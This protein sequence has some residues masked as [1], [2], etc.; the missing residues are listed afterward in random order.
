MAV[1]F[2][3]NSLEHLLAELERLDLFIRIQVWRVRQVVAVGGELQPYYVPEQEVDQLLDNMI[4]RPLW[5]AAP[6]PAELANDLQT[7]LDEMATI[8]QQRQIVARQQ[9]IRLRLNELV[10]LFDL[11]S[12][13]VDTLLL[14]LAPELD[15]GYNRLYAYLQDN[16]SRQRPTLDLLFNLFCRRIEEKVAAR[17]RFAAHAPLRHY[18]LIHLLPNTQESHAPWLAQSLKMDER[19]LNYLLDNDAVDA[20]LQPYVQL[21]QPAAVLDDLF[22]PP[23]FKE[24][25][26]GLA[27]QENTVLFYLQGPEGVGKQTTADA[28]CHFRQLRLL[29]VRGEHLATLKG[30]E[31][32][33]LAQ[34]AGREARLQGAAL[35][36]QG[37]DAL[38]TDEKKFQREQLLL[39]LATRPG[40]I[41]LAGNVPW[42]PTGGLTAVPFIHLNFPYPDSDQ[43]QQLWAGMLNG[44]AAELDL[45]DITN[46][47]RFTPGQIRDAAATAYNL[48]RRRDPERAV[49]KTEDIYTASRLHSNQKLAALAQKITPHYTWQDI[50][51]PRNCLNQLRELCQRLQYRSQVHQTWGFGAKIALGKGITALF[52][53]Q[54][55]TGK[56]MAADIIATEL[57]LDLYKIDLSTVVSKYIG[58]TEK[59][60]SRIFAEAET[61]H[62]ILFFDEADALFGKRTEVK[63]AHDRYANLEISYLL[64]K[65]EEFEGIVILATNLRQN[66][67]E[68]FARRLHYIIEFPFP[69]TP[70]RRRI[71]QGIWPEAMPLAADVDLDFMAERIAVAGGYIRNIALTAAFLAAA[72]GGQVAMAHLVQATER[73]YQKMGRLLAADEFGPYRHLV[74]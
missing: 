33:R 25:A 19:I 48:A 40:L 41:F 16:V 10:G 23:T 72:D 13:D 44:Q 64:Q 31:F 34:L 2:Y 14:C 22:L 47:F 66:M 51:L 8:N 29:V 69:T 28:L 20:S 61:S 12:F 38:L 36:W 32:L 63:D 45:A 58:E 54:P 59:N 11:T 6:L 65:M 39:L 70:D 60:L 37:F 68:A 46:K 5:K 1:D 26:R 7:T 62:A 43:R 30:D 18:Q 73:E 27:Q 24:Q 53:G 71:W 4:G 9:G 56:T 57:G 15:L 49:I 21:I 55:G 35:Y 3:A 42:Q 50:V 67:D 17:Q 52:T 74:S